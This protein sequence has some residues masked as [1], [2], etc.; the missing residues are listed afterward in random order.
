VLADPDRLV[1]ILLKGFSFLNSV[2]LLLAR[3][4]SLLLVLEL[5]LLMVVLVAVL[6]AV[7][8]LVVV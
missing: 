3:L 5:V 2:S 4:K 1:L 6:V 8:V 7:A